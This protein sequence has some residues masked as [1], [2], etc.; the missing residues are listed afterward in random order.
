[1]SH[2]TPKLGLCIVLL[3]VLAF[4]TG[5]RAADPP[6]DFWA[7]STQPA[8]PLRDGN[9]SLLKGKIVFVDGDQTLGFAIY[10]SR[11]NG[12]EKRRLTHVSFAER[13]KGVTEVYKE[14]IPAIWG[15]RG[16]WDSSSPKWSPDGKRIAFIGGGPFR[17][18]P[19]LRSPTTR[20][21]NGQVMSPLRQEV[22]KGPYA[23]KRVRDIWRMNSDGSDLRPLVQIGE[24]G[25]VWG[26]E[27]SPDGKHIAFA[28]GCR[29]N[30]RTDE[31]PFQFSVVDVDTKK[32]VPLWTRKNKEDSDRRVGEYCWSCDGKGI[33]LV[34]GSESGRKI[35]VVNIDGTGFRFL[36]RDDERVQEPYCWPDGRITFT[37]G[38]RR[39]EKWVMDP[40]GT[41]QERISRG[42]N[43]IKNPS[44]NEAVREPVVNVW[45]LALSPDR[46]RFAFFQALSSKVTGL[47]RQDRQAG[48][49]VVAVKD[50]DGDTIW[51]VGEAPGGRYDLCWEE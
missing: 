21:S 12:A 49:C 37:R 38:G 44:E 40:D 36:T 14:K 26:Y 5:V 39:G 10:S 7:A 51:E 15:D 35:G 2:I 34:I 8:Y 19:K 31:D 46:K 25:D 48:K 29:G 42:Y 6:A 30:N 11:L 47:G 33:V 24:F 22:P 23:Y 1:M 41:R 32:I 28:A 50:I 45:P 20:A 9:E 17:P 4:W 43:V 18:D 16:D 13:S 3:T 27:W